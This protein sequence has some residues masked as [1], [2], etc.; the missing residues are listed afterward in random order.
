LIVKIVCKSGKNNQTIL[1]DL[2]QETGVLRQL[3]FI[4]QHFLYHYQNKK[5]V[6]LM[7]R[8]RGR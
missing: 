1:T 7:Y 6:D 3:L 2:R 8:R 4:N 5:L